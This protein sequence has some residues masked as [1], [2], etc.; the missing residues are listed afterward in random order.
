MGTNSVLEDEIANGQERITI[1]RNG[2]V[3]KFS[4]LESNGKHSLQLRAERDGRGYTS[5]QSIDLD[6]P[7]S[8]VISTCPTCKCKTT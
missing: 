8:R 1:T 7:F 6:A 2:V 4:I 5:W 3:Y